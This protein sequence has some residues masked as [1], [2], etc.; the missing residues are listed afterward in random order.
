[1]VSTS[2]NLWQHDAQDVFAE[3]ELAHRAVHGRGQRFLTQQVTYAYV[4][5]LAAQFQRYC[6][7]VHTE[8]ALAIAR[9]IPNRALADIFERHMMEGRRLDRGNANAAN[10]GADFQRF[11]LRFWE[12]VLAHRKANRGRREKLE[13]LNGWRNAI[14]HGEIDQKRTE[15]ALL[16]D[17]IHLNVCQEWK[18]ALDG[19][20]TSFD[21]VLA[22]HCESLELPR[23]W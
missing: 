7:A 19:L 8:T 1:V 11:E 2:L 23:P 16:P 17:V 3:L 4:T 13:H 14:G 15:S 9:G 10:L 6:R 18:R 5:A 12:V 22:V 21:E 20:V